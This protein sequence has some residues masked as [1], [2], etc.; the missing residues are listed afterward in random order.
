MGKERWMS[1]AGRMFFAS[2]QENDQT[3]PMKIHAGIG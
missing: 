1:V 3:F 2:D